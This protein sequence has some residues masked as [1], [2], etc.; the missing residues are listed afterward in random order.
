MKLDGYIDYVDVWIL[1]TGP[2]WLR[3]C[4]AS[5][6][7]WSMEIYKIKSTM[8]LGLV[9]FNPC[10]A[11]EWGTGVALDK[12]VSGDRE[13]SY[14]G[15]NF[16]KKLDGPYSLGVGLHLSLDENKQIDVDESTFVRSYGGVYLARQFY[17]TSDYSVSFNGLIGLGVGTY[18]KR[19]YD[20]AG[21]CDCFFGVLRPGLS[22]N[23]RVEGGSVIS[24]TSSY[25]NYVY[26]ARDSS[27][28]V[29]V[30]YS[31]LW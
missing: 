21:T 17:L 23:Y 24:L 25:L 3:H 18:T 11:S 6:A 30:K 9:I 16:D 10:A 4:Y 1:P 31:K 2:F 28:T 14:L 26:E 29:G 13:S 22:I 7:V 19:D 15:V 20:V 12:E 5:K 8:L 27:A